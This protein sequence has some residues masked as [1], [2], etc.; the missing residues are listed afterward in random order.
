MN[1][2]TNAK[3]T[4]VDQQVFAQSLTQDSP[5]TGLSPLL[6]ALWYDAKDD[7]D[8]AHRIVQAIS[9]A[10]AA[11]VHAYLH[12]KEGDSGNADYWYS[13]A[14]RQRP[15]ISLPA[16]WRNILAELLTR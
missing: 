16:E 6:Q 14:G 4:E 2:Y 3:V 5:P 9:S 13:H 15:A 1:G 11:W 12:R 7:W 10:D 8:R